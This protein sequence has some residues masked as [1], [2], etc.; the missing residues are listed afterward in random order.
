MRFCTPLLAAILLLGCSKEGNPG[1][2]GGTGGATTAS[3]TTTPTDGKQRL[4]ILHT[5][6]WQ[7]HMLGFGP[8]TE[9]TPGSTDDDGTGVNN[10]TNGGRVCWAVAD[11]H[12]WAITGAHRVAASGTPCSL[13]VDAAKL[14]SCLTCDFF[15][16]VLQEE[17]LANFKLLRPG[18]T[19]TQV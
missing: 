16:L 4:T 17:G 11:T 19:Y 8:N 12:C 2:G 5:N 18:Q 9:Y 7:S 14:L 3:T 13:E 1:S 15:F 10:G 6:D